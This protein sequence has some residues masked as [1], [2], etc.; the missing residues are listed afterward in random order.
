MVLI[1]HVL[2]RALTHV[3]VAFIAIMKLSFS[4]ASS[5]RN[6]LISS[7]A[8]LPLNI[9]I[10]FTCLFNLVTLLVRVT[11]SR[12]PFFRRHLVKASIW[13]IANSKSLL[14]STWDSC[15][16]WCW[17]SSKAI[18]TKLRVALNSVTPSIAP[19]SRVTYHAD[20]RLV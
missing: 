5:R 19:I 8:R 7:C 1:C 16:S 18:G 10:H 14:F 17:E 12:R 13:V 6:A 2:V 11:S 9:S 4:E 15:G 3:F 20:P